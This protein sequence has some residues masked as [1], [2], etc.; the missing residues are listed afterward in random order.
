[1]Y[2]L[3]RIWFN[4]PL[5]L[6]EGMFGRDSISP[7]GAV[8]P[9]T[10]INQYDLKKSFVVFKPGCKITKTDL[11]IRVSFGEHFTAF[12]SLELVK[13]VD[14]VR[15]ACPVLAKPDAKLSIVEFRVPKELA[16]SCVRFLKNEQEHGRL[17]GMRASNG[18]KVVTES[19]EEKRIETK[20]Y[21]VLVYKQEE[22]VFVKSLFAQKL[23]PQEGGKMWAAFCSIPAF[24]EE[25]KK[26]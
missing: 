20:N 19:G 15:Q 22:S 5:Y 12:M 17:V 9:L 21:R 10:H 6:V 11:S 4:R 1:M 3:V 18:K 26:F 2:D 7:G 13:K 25:I 23:M 14:T 24:P 8:F 16:P